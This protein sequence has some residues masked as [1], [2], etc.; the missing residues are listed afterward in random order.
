M[1]KVV[2]L[3]S[4]RRTHV[5]SSGVRLETAGS[6]SK[7][8]GW[9]RNGGLAFGRVQNSGL[10]FEAVGSG[11]KWWARVS[12]SAVG[13]EMVGSSSKQCSQAG[14]GGLVFQEVGSGW[15]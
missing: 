8:W 12:S 6:H 5:R 4:K 14:N 11:L 2:G 3:S 10:M 1:F 15:K 9:A 7:Q 13:F